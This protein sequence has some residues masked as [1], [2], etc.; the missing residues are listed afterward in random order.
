MDQRY[1]MVVTGIE[2]PPLINIE[3]INPP[4]YQEKYPIE[5]C[6]INENDLT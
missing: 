3:Q 1:R 4:P 6:V 5:S 2:A